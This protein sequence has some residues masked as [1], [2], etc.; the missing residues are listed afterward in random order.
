MSRINALWLLLAAVLSISCGNNAT[1]KEAAAQPF[2]PTGV[3]QNLPQ[4]PMGTKQWHN[5]DNIGPVSNPGAN[6]PVHVSSSQDFVVSGWAIDEPNSA[7]ASN[8]DVVIDGVP[9]VAH[10]GFSRTDVADHFKQ[11]AYEKSGF[12]FSILAGQ[13]TKG[14][15]KVCIRAVA[16]DGKSYVASPEITLIVG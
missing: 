6:Q 10:Y 13:L 11:P 14:T 7:L 8:V 15:H 9:Y 12:Q 5:I 4:R 16:S 3:T 1:R 2:Q